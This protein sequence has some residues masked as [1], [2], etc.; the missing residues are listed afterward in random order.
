MLV[1][2]LVKTLFLVASRLEKRG[3]IRTFASLI[4]NTTGVYSVALWS[5]MDMYDFMAIFL[6]LLIIVLKNNMVYAF[7]NLV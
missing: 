1:D 2:I 6:T 5:L 4:L 3:L 7:V